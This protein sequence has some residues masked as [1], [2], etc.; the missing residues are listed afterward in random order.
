[1]RSELALFV[2]NVADEAYAA[3]ATGAGG[4]SVMANYGVGRSVLMQFRSDF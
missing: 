1:L 2:R 4:Q 3:W